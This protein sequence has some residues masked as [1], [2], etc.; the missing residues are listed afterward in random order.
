MSKILNRFHRSLE[1]EVRR[2]KILMA[3]AHA[4]VT[5]EE[6]VQA[7]LLEER[8]CQEEQVRRRSLAAGEL[9]LNPAMERLRALLERALQGSDARLK[10]RQRH[11]A[12]R[13]RALQEARVQEAA[14]QRLLQR[15]AR[16]DRRER[17]RREQRQLDETALL[18]RIYAQRSSGEVS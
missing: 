9:S 17:E 5:Q 7:R 12:E 4:L 11:A 8:G 14:A 13:A 6:F 1:R 16:R 3:E 2:R 18:G 15:I 10:L